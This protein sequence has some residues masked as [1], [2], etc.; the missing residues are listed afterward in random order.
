[1]PA[2][3]EEKYGGISSSAVEAK[4]GKGWKQWFAILDKAGAKK[5]KHSE[6]AA[7]LHDEC[8]CPPWWSQMVTIGYEQARGLREKHQTTSGFA[9]SVSKT[10]AAPLA[11]LFTAW[12]DAKARSAWFKD[13][14]K[15]EIRKATTNKSMRV[16][17][18]DGSTAVELNF[19]AK[20]TDKSSVVVQQRKLKDAKHV[21]KAKKYWSDALEKLKAHLEKPAGAKSAKPRNKA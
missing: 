12:N 18:A 8:D 7:H 3:T 14:T 16:T 10:I 5:W 9:A 1:M 15:I 17:G 2:T 20:G 11:K 6:I 19:Y 4:T 13:A 21:E